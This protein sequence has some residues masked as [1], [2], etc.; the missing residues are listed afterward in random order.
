[1]LLSLVLRG[2]GAGRSARA[3]AHGPNNHDWRTTAPYL[4][5]ILAR[6]RGGSMCGCRKNQR[7]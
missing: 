4:R 6:F 5:K 7:G 2:P 1:M 3:R